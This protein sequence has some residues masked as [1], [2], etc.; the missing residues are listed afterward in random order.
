MYS[1]LIIEKYLKFGN[2]IHLYFKLHFFRL[3][4]I[5]KNI[6]EFNLKLSESNLFI[7]SKI[8]LRKFDKFDWD[9]FSFNFSKYWIKGELRDFEENDCKN[10][11]IDFFN[12]IWYMKIPLKFFRIIL[13]GN[14]FRII[15]LTL[16]IWVW[17]V[18]K[19]LLI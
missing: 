13:I 17:R 14:I 11:L 10:W 12:T 1:L 8:G 18:S 19:I 16:W 4:L 6:G 2:F 15:S 5:Q 7:Y 9:N 3:H